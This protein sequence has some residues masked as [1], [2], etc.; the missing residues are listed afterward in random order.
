VRTDPADSAF[1]IRDNVARRPAAAKLW[2]TTI[3]GLAFQSCVLGI[4]T[5]GSATVS[6]LSRRHRRGQ[7]TTV[8]FSI[9]I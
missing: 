3:Q 5:T 4:A 1:L 7:G 9:P 2:L 8:T 6:T